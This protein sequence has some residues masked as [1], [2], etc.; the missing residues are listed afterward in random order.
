MQLGMLPSIIWKLFTRSMAR[1]TCILRA[2][3]SRVTYT[4]C[5]DSRLSD[6]KG[7][8]LRVMPCSVSRSPILNPLSAITLTPS[9]RRSSSPHLLVS[10][11]SEILPAQRLD[12]NIT[13]SNGQTNPYLSEYCA[14]YSSTKLHSV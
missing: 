11:I 5:S 14:I 9:S 12:T 4:S 3:I 6:I 10:S 8:M 13:L 7:G 2:A 1:S